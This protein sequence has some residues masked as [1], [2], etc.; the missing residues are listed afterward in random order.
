[1]AD[2]S[3]DIQLY[4]TQ[5]IG[6]LKDRVDEDVKKCRES[7]NVDLK[8]NGNTTKYWFA[9]ITTIVGFL[10]ALGIYGQLQKYISLR[11]NEAGLVKLKAEAE[12]VIVEIK[13]DRTDAEKSIQVIKNF[14]DAARSGQ[15]PVGT[16]IAFS[17]SIEEVKP[18]G[19]GAAVVGIKGM[20]NWLVCNGART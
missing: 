13:N 18:A 14:E 20:Q 15:L 19:K 12:N 9:G 6:K 10:A 2:I 11:L 4:V 7:M 1:M 5:E 8:E 3:S 16:I 17:G